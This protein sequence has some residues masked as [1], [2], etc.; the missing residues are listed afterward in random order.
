[1]KRKSA[2]TALLGISS[3][4]VVVAGVA[5]A[6]GN[7]GAARSKAEEVKRE[8]RAL[9]K[10]TPS[11]ARKIVKAICEAKEDDRKTAA[12]EA[13]IRAMDNVTKKY[14]SL[15]ALKDDALQKLRDVI[16]DSS[17]SKHH[18]DA[19]NYMTDIAKRWRSITNMTKSV[20]GAAHPVSK[21]VL[22]QGNLAHADYQTAPENCDVHEFPV[23][24]G[25]ADCIKAEGSVCTVIEL[26]PDNPNAIKK[27]KVQA[28]RYMAE[29]RKRD[30]AFKNLVKKNSAF[31]K[32]ESFTRR[33]HCYTLCPE[34]DEDGEFVSATPT[35]RRNCR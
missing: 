19:R 13:G 22:E 35:W 10:V 3:A 7:W 30:D 18:R 21:F 11:E 25:R 27:G 26:K 6:A 33:V 28:R 23:G 32:C 16:A 17:L 29:L 2:V 15:E 34:I 31:A 5:G 14:T 9:S 12:A 1:M 20:R 8:H 24:K 4:L